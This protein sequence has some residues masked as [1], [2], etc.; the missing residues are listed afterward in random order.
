MLVCSYLQ[1]LIKDN[2]SQ[3]DEKLRYT[4]LYHFEKLQFLLYVN[5]K[6]VLNIFAHTKSTAK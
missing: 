1:G 3:A 4:G 6:N 2:V 5:N